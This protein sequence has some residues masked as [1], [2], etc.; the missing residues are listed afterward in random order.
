MDISEADLDKHCYL[1]TAKKGK[2]TFSILDEKR[3]EAV[4]ILQEQCGFP[5]DKDFIHSLECNSIDGVDFGRR[6]VNIANKIYGYSKGAA[7]GTFK[8]PHK[9]VKMDRTTEDIDTPVPLE[10]IKH[11]KVIY[12]DIDILFINK[13]AFLLAIP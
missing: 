3:V 9:G 10:I 4:R 11:Y 8:H 5:S 1:N 6:N 13:T 7:I 2:T 12:L